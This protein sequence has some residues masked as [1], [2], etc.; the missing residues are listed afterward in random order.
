MKKKK[1]KEQKLQRG[2][3]IVPGLAGWLSYSMM[4]CQSAERQSSKK[5][6]E[7]RASNQ[8]PAMTKA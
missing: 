4:A 3:S 2:S 6:A 8:S 7:E 5:E 1:R